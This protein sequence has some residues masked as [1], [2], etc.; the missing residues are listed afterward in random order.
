[1][2]FKP[3]TIIR[4]KSTGKYPHKVLHH[5]KGA[6]IVVD[7]EDRRNPTPL[8]TIQERDFPNWIDE[9]YLEVREKKERLI[10]TLAP[11]I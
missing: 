7:L 8:T 2:S 3:G 5:Y 4:D 10:W 11:V 9:K 6:I 1:M